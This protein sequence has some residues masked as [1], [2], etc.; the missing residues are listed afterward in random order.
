MR[1][2]QWL[3]GPLWMCSCYQNGCSCSQL[4]TRIQKTPMLV[5]Q[6]CMKKTSTQ[7]CHILYLLCRRPNRRDTKVFRKCFRNVVVAISTPSSGSSQ[8]LTQH[9]LTL[10]YRH[11][12]HSS[13]M[14]NQELSQILTS[15]R[16]SCNWPSR[17]IVK[18][19]TF[20]WLFSANFMFVV[21]IF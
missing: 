10:T 3:T 19:E 21:I 4:M 2:W 12:F 6:W 5:V 18:G 13:H 16:K 9:Q 8:W 1:L 7:P 17:G 15:S 20:S 11:F 14:E